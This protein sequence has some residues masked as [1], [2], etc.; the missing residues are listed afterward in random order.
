MLRS[1]D[2]IK[3]LAI[4]AIDD[5]IGK[6]DQFLFDDEHWTVR[7]MVV[8]TAGWLLKD[9]VLISPR[10]IEGVDWEAGQV[11]VNLTRQQVE[12]APAIATDAPVSRQMEAEL[13]AHYDYQPYWYGP[14]LW[15]AGAYPFGA[16]FSSGYSAPGAIGGTAALNDPSAGLN[17]TERE[18]R[19]QRGEH[20]D[21]HLRS[22]REVN[23]YA[24]RARDGDVGKVS[25][26]I[27]D[28]ETWAIRYL[29]ID[30]G[31]WW[32]GRQVLIAPLWATAVSWE[33]QVI[34]MDLIRDQVKSGP[35]YSR[36]QLRREDEQRLH[37]HYR[38]SGYWEHVLF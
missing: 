3:S 36:E 6:V 28:D 8:N 14:G 33:N 13:A 26:F 38:R 21:Q 20:G 27:L 17:A 29:V 34:E 32:S 25:D 15:G 30:T 19:P 12:H 11:A 35:E 16:G 24:I 5:E 4:R 18:Q 31:G 1:G 10:S 9:L 37:Q 2:E 23:G 7:Y 22:T